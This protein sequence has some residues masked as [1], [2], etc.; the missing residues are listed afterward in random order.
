MK[1]KTW[2]TIAAFG[3]LAASQAQAAD[4]LRIAT[5]GTFPPYSVAAP[6]GKLSGFDVDIANALC[7]EMKAKCE[8]MRYDFDGMIPALNARK[9][10]LIV[11]SM[12]I[13]PEREKAVSFSNK[14]EGGYSQFLGKKGPLPAGTPASMKGKTL[15]V[16]QGTIQE[17]YAKDVFGKGGAKIRTYTTPANALLD[18]NAG[19]VDAIMVEIGVGSE[20]LKGPG[21]NKLALFGPKFSDV[22]YFG[23]GSG[24]ALRKTDKALLQKVNTALDTILKNGTY[25]KINDRYFDYNQ[26]D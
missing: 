26:Y 19:R 5:D 13:T 25:K 18:L 24:I 21:G 12:A 1:L 6:D 17:K 4:T 11:A 16:Q 23:T 14:Y 7:A 2:T 22:K 15:G 20:F 9:F 3:L 10:D 8:I